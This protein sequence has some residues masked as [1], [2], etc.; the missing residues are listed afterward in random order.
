MCCRPLTPS[1]QDK[2]LHVWVDVDASVKRDSTALVACTYSI[3][4]KCVRLIAHRVFTP[5][6]DDAVD[7]EATVEAAILDWF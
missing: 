7:F 5:S 4:P 6:P 2:R 1:Q 3:Q